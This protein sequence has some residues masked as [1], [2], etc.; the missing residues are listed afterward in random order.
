MGELAVTVRLMQHWDISQCLQ[1]AQPSKLPLSQAP[2]GIASKIPAW[3]TVV[4]VDCGTHK[5]V[6][7]LSPHPPHSQVLQVHHPTEE[8][9]RQL[10]DVI[11]SQ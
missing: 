7:A 6:P 3:N 10:T 11:V 2:D 1:L 5:A 8:A 4:S 9:L